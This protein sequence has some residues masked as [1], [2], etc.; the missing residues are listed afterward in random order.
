MKIAA[1]HI[2]FAS[3]LLIMLYVRYASKERM[4]SID[5]INYRISMKYDK[6]SQQ[7]ALKKLTHINSMIISLVRHLRNKYIRDNSGTKR[8]KRWAYNVWNRFDPTSISENVPLSTKN[9]SWVKN[10]GEEMSLCLREKK[11]GSNQLH[12]IKILEFVALHELSHIAEDNYGHERSFWEAFKFILTEAHNAGLHTPR[13][14]SKTPTRY[15]G[16]LVDYNP[17]FDSELSY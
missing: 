12:N 3:I 14:Y 4:M 5:G 7:E 1:G 2:I 16:I 11:S 10:K 6:D 17:Y 8:Q 9:T 15:C 13:N